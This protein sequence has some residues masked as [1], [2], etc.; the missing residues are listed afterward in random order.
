MHFMAVKK[1][2]KRSVFV[3]FSYQF[4]DNAFTVVKRDAKF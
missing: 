1:S 4:K 2:I 3:T